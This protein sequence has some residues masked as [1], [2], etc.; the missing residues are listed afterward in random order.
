MVWIVDWFSLRCK[1]LGVSWLQSR[2]CTCSSL[3]M[4]DEPSWVSSRFRG[5]A[6]DTFSFRLSHENSKGGQQI[7]DQRWWWCYQAM[8]FSCLMIVSS[9]KQGIYGLNRVILGNWSHWWDAWSSW[10]SRLKPGI[11][12]ELMVSIRISLESSWMGKAQYFREVLSSF[13]TVCLFLDFGSV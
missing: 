11:G 3:K 6:D 8:L 5:T 1:L 4:V 12:L 9:T 13:P 2:D 7:T 10:D